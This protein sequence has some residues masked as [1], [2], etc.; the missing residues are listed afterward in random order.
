VLLI[1]LW[2]RSASSFDEIGIVMSAQGKLYFFPD[3]DITPIHN[4]PASLQSYETLGGFVTTLKVQNVQIARR[5]GASP[6]IPLWPLVLGAWLLATLPWLPQ[7]FSLR[8][9]LFATTLIAVVLG[10]IVYATRQ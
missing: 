7:R 5:P 4:Q 1:V 10:V 8:T 6:V 9:L 3:V 2:V